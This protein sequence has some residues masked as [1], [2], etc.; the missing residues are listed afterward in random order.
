MTGPSIVGFAG[1][2][3][4]PS[5]TRSLVEKI[6]SDT[7]ARYDETAKVYDILDLGASLGLA[8]KLDDLDAAAR[9]V[10]HDIVNAKALVI[11]TPVYK[12]SYPGLF[13]HLID[14]L[15][16]ATLAGKPV[17][18]AATG[19]G[20]KHALVIEHQLRPLFAFFEAQTLGTGIYASDRDFENGVLTNPAVLDRISRA[21]GQ[22]EAH[23]DAE[24]V[25]ADDQIAESWAEPR[26]AAAAR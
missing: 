7:S 24:D 9:A 18:L 11:A 19:G 22:F 13:K 26:S 10:I 17:L 15:D 20:E 2:A 5:K 23:L 6:V 21:V 12:G 4:K 14:L 3:S 25:D 8:R 16:P 1:S